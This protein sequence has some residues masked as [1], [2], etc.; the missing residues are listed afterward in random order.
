MNNDG[1]N[2]AIVPLC[3]SDQWIRDLE[4]YILLL[5]AEDDQTIPAHLGKQLFRY[6][7]LVEKCI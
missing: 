1:D 3:S 4:T 5:Q 7:Y 2:S 6:T